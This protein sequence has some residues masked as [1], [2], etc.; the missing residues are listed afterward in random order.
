MQKKKNLKQNKTKKKYV[1]YRT[2][3]TA[4]KSNI[5]QKKGFVS[6]WNL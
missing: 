6:R 4:K 3:D 1:E 5:T 2:V